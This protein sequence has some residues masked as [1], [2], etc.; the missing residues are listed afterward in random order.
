MSRGFVILLVLQL[1]SCFV[2]LSPGVAAEVRIV[3][4]PLGDDAAVGDRVQPLCTLGAA[5][6]R[7]RAALTAGATAVTVTLLAGRWQL[8]APLTLS[9]DDADGRA[10]V[11]WEADVPGRAVISVGREVGPWQPGTRPGSWRAAVPPDLPVPQCLFDADHWLPPTLHDDRHLEAVVDPLHVR[12]APSPPIGS[13]WLIIV[14]EWGIGRVFARQDAGATQASSAG[15]VVADMIQSE[16]IPDKAIALEGW[17]P[18]S[19]TGWGLLDDGRSVEMVAPTK[20]VPSWLPAAESALIIRGTAEHPVRRLTLS[21]I[22]LRHAGWNPPATGWAG[23]QAGVWTTADQRF[24]VQPAACIVTYA[25]DVSLDRL[26]VAACAGAGIAIGRDCERVVVSRC[27]VQEVGGNGIWIGWRGGLHPDGMLTALDEDWESAAAAPRRCVIEGC[28]VR[29][30]G[31]LDWG[32]VGICDQFADGSRIRFNRLDDLPY[33]GISSGFVWRSR[34]SSQ[35]RGLIEGNDIQRVMRRMGDGAGIYTLGWQPG[36]VIRG[37][38]I[39]NVQRHPRATGS[40]NAGMYFDQCS[41][42]ILVEG[43]Q[44][45]DIAGDPVRFNE[46]LPSAIFTDSDG[47]WSVRPLTLIGPEAL[48]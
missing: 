47:G 15:L 2:S 26:D 24:R 33:S 34:R 38:R 17:A 42:G 1:L 23:I 44:L 37:N 31:R 5:Q 10:A 29:G 6:L 18:A 16:L 22:A 40:A 9:G 3:V 21:G 32:S 46:V 12:V 28:T 43:D 7:A 45:M 4:S 19:P 35:G 11:R 13:G 14:H 41:R 48:K 36:A 39:M 20:P 30:A 25:A 27:T 8:S